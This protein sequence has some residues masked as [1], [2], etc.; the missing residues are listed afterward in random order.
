M[1]EANDTMEYIDLSEE[2][3]TKRQHYVPKAYLKE[4]SFDEQK[5]SH[6]YAV[7][8][9]AKESVPVSI[10]KICCQSY[11]YEQIAV[12]SDNGAH[13]F[14]APNE[15]EGFFSAIEGRYAAIISKVTSD[16]HEKNDFEKN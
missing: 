16:L 3:L 2:Q 9:N 14:A 10:E 13:V 11:L 6:V 8:P 7:F 12:D 4:F 15:L 5:V 1:G